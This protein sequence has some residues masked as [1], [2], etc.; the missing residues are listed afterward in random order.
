MPLEKPREGLERMALIGTPNVGKSMLFGLMTGKYATV[1]NH[2]G[3]IVEA[4]YG[5]LNI[6]E[7]RYLLVDTPTVQEKKE[8]GPPLGLPPACL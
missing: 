1:S 6:G 8:G 2:P 5:N 3:A 4:T 7:G